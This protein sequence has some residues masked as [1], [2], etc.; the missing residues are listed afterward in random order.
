MEPLTTSARGAI[1]ELTEEGEDGAIANPP[2]TRIEFL[3]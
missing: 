3:F 1:D 2:K